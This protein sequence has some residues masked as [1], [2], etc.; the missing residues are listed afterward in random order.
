MGRLKCCA[1]IIAA[2]AILSAGSLVFIS[3]S[4]DKL[5]GLLDKTAYAYENDGDTLSAIEELCSF[6][7]DYYIR[8]SYVLRTDSLNSVSSSVYRL[9][10]LYE[11]GSDEFVSELEN[12][13]TQTYLYYQSQ[14]PRLYSVL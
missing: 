2:I 10:Y 4:N 3:R 13:R 9:K 7:E 5:Y 12:I 1:A 6:W 11:N 8:T 14:I